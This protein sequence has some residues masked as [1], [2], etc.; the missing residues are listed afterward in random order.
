[1]INKMKKDFAIFTIVQNEKYFLPKL[2]KYY[3]QYV[4]KS[5]FY[6]LDHDSTDGSTDN[7]DVNVEKVSYDFSFDHVWLVE[8][9]QAFQQK[10]LMKYK[11][12]IFVEAD[13]F[14]YNI[15]GDFLSILA[16]TLKKY[17]TILNIGY[18]IV[19]D[20]ANEESNEEFNL[21]DEEF[22]KCSIKKR[23]YWARKP[24][25]D[26]PLITKV[27]I[28]YRSGFHGVNRKVY[29]RLGCSLPLAIKLP[30]LFLAHLHT[31]DWNLN[32][33]R[34]SHR[35]ADKT[36]S[37][38]RGARHNKNP[39][40]SK[41]MDHFLSFINRKELIPEAHLNRMIELGI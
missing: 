27:P 24:N 22:L 2:I 38:G 18:N 29:G 36:L 13:D 37:S 6:V 30:T 11:Y 7:L 3:T 15:K 1:M 17:D 41:Q 25:H 21:S 35:V 39:K 8:T 19:H 34:I 20:F 16:D 40:Q 26:K 5:D 31:V 32:N 14:L 9:V 4:D 12:V 33:K 10:L 23:K 28:Y